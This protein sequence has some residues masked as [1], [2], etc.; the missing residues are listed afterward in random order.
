VTKVRYL[1][2]EEALL[3]CEL[4]GDLKVR[5]LGL[6]DSA[7][8]RPRAAYAGQEAYPTVPLKAAALLHSVAKNHPLFDG[9]KRLAWMTCDVFLELNGYDVHMSQT[10]VVRLVLDVA[11]SALD[12][13]EAIA[14]RINA[15]PHL[16]LHPND[17]HR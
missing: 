10:D 17:E 5:D 8:H 1:T 15:L 11:S 6:L 9:N 14:A 7:L 3:L 4:L 13:V 2:V 12:D 16:P